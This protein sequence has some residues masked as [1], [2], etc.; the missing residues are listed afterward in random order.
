MFKIIVSGESLVEDS[1]R[2]LGFQNKGRF[3]LL[4]SIV[5]GESLVVDSDR[6]I[7]FRDRARLSLLKI[8]YPA[9]RW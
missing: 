3:L 4:N 1:N 2:L 5:S 7:G 6:L 9:N 8:L